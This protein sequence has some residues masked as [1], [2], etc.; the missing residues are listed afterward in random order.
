MSAAIF[1]AGMML[2]AIAFT[3]AAR[4]D[5][6]SD[7]R[8]EAQTLQK[9]NEALARRLAAI[10]KR[11]KDLESSE[12]RVM[13]ASAADMPVRAVKAVPYAPV[14]DA[15]C[16]KGI[17]AYGIVDI[18][19]GYQTHGMPF[20][21]FGTTGAQYMVTAGNNRPMFTA[22]ENAMS[23]S[24]LGLKGS[25]EI[26]PGVNGVFKLDT[27]FNPMSGQLTNGEASLIQ[28][29]GLS[30]L[31]RSTYGDSNRNGQVFNGQAYVGVSS[32]TY[33]T[34][35]WGRNNALT[36]DQILAYDP[37]GASYAFSPLGFS[38]AW[39]GAGST[40]FARLDQSIKYVVNVGPVHAG[41]IYQVGNYG[42]NTQTIWPHDDLQ[43]NVGFNYMGLSVDGTAGKIR[44]MVVATSLAPGAA[45]VGLPYLTGTVSDNTEWMIT[46]KYKWDRFEVLGGYEHFDFANP[47]NPVIGVPNGA[48]PAVNL[49]YNA[50]GTLMTPTNNA[51]PNDKIVQMMWIGGKWKATDNLTL[52]AAF[53]H[54]TQNAFDIA[55]PSAG[56]TKGAG[57]STANSSLCSGSQDT[58]SFVADYVFNK[59]F[60]VY[61]G[62]AYSQ[63][64]GGV[65]AGFAQTQNFNASGM[66]TGWNGKNSA[67]NLDPTVGA[68]YSF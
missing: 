42:N 1:A 66:A 50:Y 31:Q 48:V 13:N 60:D 67:N 37:L 3:G 15:L 20:N 52:I 55:A 44:G 32:P 64:N 22:A 43:G 8:A 30:L 34:L 33:G 7:L 5:E 23:Q 21:G 16:W 54:Q 38:G 51:Y 47:A 2:P 62:V 57:C 12:R 68:R 4:A 53:Y 26:L 49:F 9:Q 25:V 29:N 65:A 41:V 27:G 6:V 59:H 63:A 61:A 40:E 46:A 10:E 28:Q 11:Q 14:D 36:L 56:G 58:V 45:N 39:T 35:T 18:G 24:T 17:C 19:F